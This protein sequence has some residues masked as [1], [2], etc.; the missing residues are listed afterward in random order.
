MG[1][2]GVDVRPAAVQLAPPADEVGQG[3]V[4]LWNIQVRVARAGALGELPQDGKAGSALSVWHMQ[5]LHCS[6]V[7]AQASRQG[8]RKTAA[9]WAALKTCAASQS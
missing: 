4:G 3:R 7:R 8:F 1:Q 6:D 5:P 2:G 9:S